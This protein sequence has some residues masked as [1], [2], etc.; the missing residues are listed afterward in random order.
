[1]AGAVFPPSQYTGSVRRFA[2]SPV[3]RY[4]VL[5]AGL[6]GM[7]ALTVP[8]SRASFGLWLNIGLWI[9][10]AY[11]AMDGVVRLSTARRTGPALHYLGTPTGI[12]DLVSIVPVPLALMCGVP[13]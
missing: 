4:V 8:E 1:M 5:G 6:V 11:F 2:V 9:C 12:I 13:P 10:L 3:T 7:T